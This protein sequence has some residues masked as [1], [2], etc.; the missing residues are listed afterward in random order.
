MEQL[1]SFDICAVQHGVPVTMCSACVGPYIENLRA[2]QD[3][4]T[5]TDP[6][7]VRER[8]IDHFMNHDTLNVLWTEYQGSRNLWNSAACT[9]K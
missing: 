6:K 2:F 9:S 4:I 5:N 7:S 8:C 1:K 3:L